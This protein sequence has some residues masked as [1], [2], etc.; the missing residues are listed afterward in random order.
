MA[1]VKMVLQ[2]V[3]ASSMAERGGKIGHG[4]DEE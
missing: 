1:V 3:R 2:L 4:V